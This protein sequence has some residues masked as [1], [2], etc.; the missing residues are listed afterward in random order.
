MSLPNIIGRV[1]IVLSPLSIALTTFPLLA[2]AA[3]G[4]EVAAGATATAAPMLSCVRISTAAAAFRLLG[5]LLIMLPRYRSIRRLLVLLQM[6]FNRFE[7][8][9]QIPIVGLC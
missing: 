7:L 8:K 6:S 4:T 2:A 5:L 3:A 1:A 9:L